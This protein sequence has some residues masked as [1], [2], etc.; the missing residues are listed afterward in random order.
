MLCPNPQFL[1]SCSLFATFTNLTSFI[2]H[3]LKG[4]VLENR[5]QCRGILALAEAFHNR[6][7]AIVRN[8]KKSRMNHL[9]AQ[10]STALSARSSYHDVSSSKPRAGE[11]Y[12]PPW[13]STGINAHSPK[14]FGFWE[15]AEKSKS[16]IAFIRNLWVLPSDLTMCF[17]WWWSE[18]WVVR[19]RIDARLH[20]GL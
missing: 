14:V 16:H 19:H 3:R 13:S 4:I 18:N 7:V 12:R 10:G 5:S 9:Y 15:A 2:H 1:P 6:N 11:L 17:S 20:W 8:G